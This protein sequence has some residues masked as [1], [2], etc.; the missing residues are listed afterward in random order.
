[1]PYLL[2]DKAGPRFPH[3]LPAVAVSTTTNY[4]QLLAGLSISFWNSPAADAP[5]LV[6]VFSVSCL[7][8]TR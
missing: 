3:S 5:F 4:Q 6:Q 7:G 8:S 2:D 1:M